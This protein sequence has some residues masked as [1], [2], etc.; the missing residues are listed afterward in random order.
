[1]N[2]LDKLPRRN[3]LGSGLKLA[4]AGFAVQF[5]GQK[6]QAGFWDIFAK[7]PGKL[8]AGAAVIDI[9]PPAGYRMS[10]Y[11]RER[12]NTGILNRL[13]A[14]ALVLRQ[15]KQRAAFVFCDIIGISPDVSSKARQTAAQKTSIP[16]ENILITATHSHTGPLYWGALR[17]Y[18]HRRAVEKHGSDPQEK[19]DYPSMLIEKIV[20]AITQA[21]AKTKPVRLDAGSAHQLGLSFNRRFHMKDGTVRFNPGYMNPNVVK[22][23]GPIDPELPIVF[24][25]DAKSSKPLAAIVNFALHLDTVGGTKYAADYPYYLQQS[26]RKV[27]GND[28][29][30]FFG[31]GT[32]GDINHIDVTKK[33]R[34]KT[35]YIGN[36]LAET[37]KAKTAELTSVTKPA[38]AVRSKI[39]NVPLQ[40]FSAEETAWA[41]E[42]I[43]KVE[44]ADSPFLEKVKAYKIIA[45][46]ARKSDTIGLEVQV[47][48]LSN[49]IAV[50]GLPGEVFVDIGLAIKKE[51]PFKTTLIIELCQDCPGYIPTRKAFAEGSYETVNSRIAP[52]GGEAMTKEAI[53]LLKELGAAISPLST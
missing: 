52:G 26:L 30:S 32:C 1:M 6:T 41:K 22:A 47:F 50:V 8:K 18:L 43:K 46:E 12:L 35:D 3:F 39:V 19:V 7:S 25:R 9:T 31:I 27:Y 23:A 10:G 44:T 11:F 53:R 15:G 14:K 33:Q 2:V 48:R 38:L 42:N 34:L 21:D 40:R 5:S 49:D 20:D 4:T 37:V 29:V 16:A 51:S 28:F 45:V 17:D 36:T 24:I 13:N